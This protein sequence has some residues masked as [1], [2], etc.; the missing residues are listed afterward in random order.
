V[1]YGAEGLFDDIKSLATTKY[2]LGYQSVW[3]MLGYW[4]LLV[5]AVLVDTFAFE[6]IAG[7]WTQIIVY[8]I[9]VPVTVGLGIWLI[10]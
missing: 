4:A 7:K 10:P 8:T 3:N 9:G 1:R 5:I 6:K 2:L